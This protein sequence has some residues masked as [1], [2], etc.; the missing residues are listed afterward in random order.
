[1]SPPPH[2]NTTLMLGTLWVAHSDPVCVCARVCEISEPRS[3]TEP[4]CACPDEAEHV[5]PLRMTHVMM[6]ELLSSCRRFTF[7]SL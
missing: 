2:T 7:S 4:P 5:Q 3:H 6:E 1:M